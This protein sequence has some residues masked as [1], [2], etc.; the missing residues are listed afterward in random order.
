MKGGEKAT[1]KDSAALARYR[2]D[3]VRY[4]Q[5]VLGVQVVG[6]AGGGGAGADAA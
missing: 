4:A 6:Q 3:P 5:E 2:N 1:G